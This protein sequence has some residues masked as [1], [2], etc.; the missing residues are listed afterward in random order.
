MPICYE[1]WPSFLLQFESIYT[2]PLQ[3]P[4]NKCPKV[5]KKKRCKSS[6]TTTAMNHNFVEPVRSNLY[7]RSTWPRIIDGEKREKRRKRKV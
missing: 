4:D 5:T 1:N 7:L 2:P 3:P 6:V